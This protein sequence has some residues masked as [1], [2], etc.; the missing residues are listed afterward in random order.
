[1][2]F[3]VESCHFPGFFS[4]DV[5]PSG[6]LPTRHDSSYRSERFMNYLHNLAIVSP[7]AQAA[8]ISDIHGTGYFNQPSIRSGY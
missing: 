1:M 7:R 3:Q 4:V 2:N 5:Y 6:L 8:G